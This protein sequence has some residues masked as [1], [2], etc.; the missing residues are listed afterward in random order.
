MRHM[1]R[2]SNQLTLRDIDPRVLAEI[3]RV[4][5]IEGL[6]LNKAAAKILK[7][8]AGVRDAEESRSIGGAVDRFVGSLPSAEARRI[9]QSLRSLEQVD[10]ELWK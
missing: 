9:S 1:T 3:E 4:A 6:S 10:D 2:R 5:R 7:V 8:G